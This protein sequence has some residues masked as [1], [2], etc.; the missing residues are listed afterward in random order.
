[1]AISVSPSNIILILVI[2]IPCAV[3]LAIL[4][5]TVHCLRK[6][7]QKRREAA[8]KNTD[9][10]L[11]MRQ[12]HQSLPPSL[13]NINTDVPPV[14]RFETVSVST[15]PAHNQSARLA[16]TRSV[17]AASS[18]E[19]L[20]PPTKSGSLG[21]SVQ[22]MSSTMSPTLGNQSPVHTPLR[23]HTVACHPASLRPGAPLERHTN[24]SMPY[25]ASR[26]VPPPMGRF[27]EGRMDSFSAGPTT[28]F[29][30]ITA[31]G[32]RLEEVVDAI[33]VRHPVQVYDPVDCRTIYHG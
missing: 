10:E 22:L 33:G 4:M 6:R 7:R 12:T 30:V 16:P 19:M 23:S 20:C 9:S 28:S 17:N 5:G 21:S 8:N 26:S 1:M 29:R 3:V 13:V 27:R 2:T 15:R 14:R 11:G 24:Q 18:N 25:P 32:T 31:D